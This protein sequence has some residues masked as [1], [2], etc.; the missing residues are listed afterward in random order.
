MPTTKE[1]DDMA[2]E[3]YKNREDWIEITEEGLD[4]AFQEL[5]RRLRDKQKTVDSDIAKAVQEGYWDMLGDKDA[6]K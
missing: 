2:R 4:A 3:A 6:H 1:L 5:Q